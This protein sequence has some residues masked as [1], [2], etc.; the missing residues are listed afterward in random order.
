M[1][2]FCRL[3]PPREP[4]SEIERDRERRRDDS[5]SGISSQLCSHESARPATA[6]A[7]LSR[8]VKTQHSS[9]RQGVWERGARPGRG[10]R[11]ANPGAMPHAPI[12]PTHAR[13]RAGPL[14]LRTHWHWLPRAGGHSTG[15]R[16]WGCDSRSAAPRPPREQARWP[17][18]GAAHG[19]AAAVFA[20]QRP[21]DAHL[22]GRGGVSAVGGTRALTPLGSSLPP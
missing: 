13:A 12:P 10:R 21:G 6:G 9:A 5:R 2:L 14:A 4:R 18:I 17:P 7:A 20:A 15:G 3:R 16:D 1:R 22:A 11:A 8:G 19:R